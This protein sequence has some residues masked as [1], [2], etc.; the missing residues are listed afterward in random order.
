M[1]LFA[2]LSVLVL[3]LASLASPA[4]S[5]AATRVDVFHFETEIQR[6]RYRDLIAELRCPKCLNI[7]IAGSDAP[8]AQ[9][10]RA[11][12]HR[13]V[14]IE[15]KTDQ[16]VLDFVHARYGDFV[17]YDPPLNQRTWIIWFAPAA[18]GLLVIVVL[19]LLRRRALA[20]PEVQMTAQDQARLAQILEEE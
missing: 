15:G 7:N 8:I 2:Q 6:E 10:L 4:Q 16:E 9:D 20:K 18:I 19:V 17:L 12:V 1:R 11:L 14:V 3:V 5:V 13:L